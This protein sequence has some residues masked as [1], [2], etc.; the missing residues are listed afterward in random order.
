MKNLASAILLIVS[1]TARA[2]EPSAQALIERHH[3]E[4]S[5]VWADHDTVTFFYQGKA[6]KVSVMFNG[7]IRDLRRL[8]DSDVWVFRLKLPDLN[9]AVFSFELL[10]IPKNKSRQLGVQTWRGP[11]SPPPP[12]KAD[13][14]IGIISEH[15][16]ES[17]VLDCK[18]AVTVYRPPDY[19]R[20]EVKRVVYAAD[21]QGV[22]EFIRVL[23]P[24]IVSGRVPP[25]AIIGVHHGGYLG[26]APD[27]NNYDPEKDLRAQDL[28]W[29]KPEH[30]VKHD[31]FFSNE[32]RVWAE[33]EFGVS[34]R[35][36]DRVVFGY[37]NGG[38]F[39]VEMGLRHPNVFGHVFGF[40]VPGEREHL[41]ELPKDFKDPPQFYLSAGTWEETFHQYTA[42][43]GNELKKHSVPVV[44]ASRVGGHDGAIWREEFAAAMVSAFGKK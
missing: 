31:A 13:K 5:S 10:P 37:S 34:S 27:L 44:F 23:E 40:S 4:K 32:V 9:K 26:G 22:G 39:A 29:V 42:A 24:L 28:P 41:R 18:R 11:Q 8:P 43:L 35:C 25:T 19:A 36:K 12:Q 15:Q 2:D 17:K 7:N 16:V 38:R 20:S 21:G 3:K 33:R 6:D 14:L 30:F 1:L